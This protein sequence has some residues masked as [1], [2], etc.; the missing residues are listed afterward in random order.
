[1]L[2]HYSAKPFNF[3][4]SPVVDPMFGFDRTFLCQSSAMEMLCKEGMDFN[5]LV[6]HGIRYLSRDE[7]MD[8]RARETDRVNGVREDIM[9]DVGGENFL[10]NA[11]Y[12]HLTIEVTSGFKFKIG[13]RILRGR[14]MTFVIFQL[15]RHITN[16]FYIKLYPRCFL[17]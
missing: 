13:S 4:V 14:N 6:R 2:G 7:E 9:I 17:I 15:H 12:F 5:R 10:D 3:F 1:M 16:G 8:I 11:R